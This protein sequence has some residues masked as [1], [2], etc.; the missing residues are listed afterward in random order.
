MSPALVL[1]KRLG[2]A[3]LVTEAAELGGA[4]LLGVRK[5]R[6]LLLIAL[7]NFLTNVAL[8]LGLYLL[9]LQHTLEE[10]RL[11]ILA[12]ELLVWGLEWLIYRLGGVSA[13]VRPWLL[14]L[15]LNVASYLLGL[16][17]L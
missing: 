4:L 8:N 12:A 16:F 15:I 1:L 14:A 11:F 2:G 5:G 17:L 10:L 13:K 9:L 3:L 7:A 6:E